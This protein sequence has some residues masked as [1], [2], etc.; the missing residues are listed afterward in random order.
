MFMWEIIL[1]WMTSVK[2][3]MVFWEVDFVTMRDHEVAKDQNQT[4]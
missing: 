4:L 3:S 1:G 2:F